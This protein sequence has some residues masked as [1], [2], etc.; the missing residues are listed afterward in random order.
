MPI[1]W[2]SIAPPEFGSSAQTLQQGINTLSR[3]LDKLG[4]AFYE[5]PMQQLAE[6]AK[7]AEIGRLKSQTKAAEAQTRSFDLDTATKEKALPA[8]GKLEEARTNLLNAQ[9]I[10]AETAAKASKFQ[11]SNAAKKQNRDE[12]LEEVKN[13]LTEYGTI[14]EGPVERRKLALKL[15]RDNPKLNTSNEDDVLSLVSGEYAGRRM[16]T[17]SQTANIAAYK[18]EQT[19]AIAQEVDRLN[20]QLVSLGAQTGL[21]P[22]ML[23]YEQTPQSIDDVMERY[24]DSRLDFG[25]LIRTYTRVN[26][27]PPTGNDLELVLSWAFDRGIWSQGVSERDIAAGIEK[28]RALRD[29]KEAQTYKD[30]YQGIQA[31]QQKLTEQMGASVKKFTKQYEN[32]QAQKYNQTYDGSEIKI[33][34]GVVASEYGLKMAK[35]LRTAMANLLSKNPP[36]KEKRVNRGEEEEVLR[37]KGFNTYK[38]PGD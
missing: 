19:G 6:E 27:V 30:I 34:E 28:F 9:A 1:T 12:G 25:Y 37:S 8:I 36:P 31:Y 18:Q 16:L 15:I 10:Q 26:K 2:R 5:D 29:S 38:F 23:G 14:P 13:F 11:A 21:N 32:V 7:Q 17:E 33:P 22:R 4:G 20:Q 3:G 35:D 24:K